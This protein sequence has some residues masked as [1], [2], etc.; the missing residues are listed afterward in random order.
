[1][2]IRDRLFRWECFQWRCQGVAALRLS[3]AERRELTGLL[4]TA[5][6]GIPGT[7]AEQFADPEPASEAGAALAT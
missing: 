1:M 7:G 4:E 2:C 5:G 3:L 6:E